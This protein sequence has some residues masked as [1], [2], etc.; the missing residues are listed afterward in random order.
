MNGPQQ[1]VLVLGAGINGVAIA[2]ELVLNGLSVCLVDRWDIAGGTTAY[3]S[4]LIHGGLRYLEYGDFQLVRESLAERERLLRLAPQFVRPLRLF[5][6]IQRRAS[7]VVAAARK[8][9]GWPLPRTGKPVSRGLWLVQTGLQLYDW[10]AGRSSLPRHQTLAVGDA[11][12]PPVDSERFHW[13]TSY[14]DAQIEFPE[15][16]VVAM[17][18]D[19][20]QVASE[21]GNELDVLTYHRATLSGR[22][23]IV[24][25]LAGPEPAAGDS[26][27]GQQ[28][29]SLTPAAIINATGAWVDQTLTGLE[30]PSPR[31]IGG[32]K[33]SHFLTD[34]AGLREALSGCGIYAEARDGRPVFLLPLGAFSMVGT[35]D[36]PYAQEPHAAVASDAELEY[37]MR[38]VGDVFPHIQLTADDIALHYCGVRPLPY[39]SPTSPASVTRRHLLHEHTD[40]EVP[41]ISIIGGKLTTCRSLAEETAQLVLTKLGREVT[42][43]SRDRVIPGGEDYPE[44]DQQLTD[45]LDDVA[46]KCGLTQR[47]VAAV[48]RLC[49]T[50]AASNLAESDA[51]VTGRDGQQNLSG[52]DLPLRFVR[53]VIRREWSHHLTDLV[54]RRLMLLFSPDLTLA[55]LRHLAQVMVEESC[56]APHE[57]DAEIDVC[58]RRLRT[59]FGRR[60]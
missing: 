2:R 9:F 41:T 5:I 45:R 16:F 60:I 50:R 31:L 4:R 21:Q 10:S 1:N 24:E 27:Q 17:L 30:I 43:T 18:S 13:V 46:R 35:T 51:A 11:K 47:Q 33:G 3:S 48:F 53:H 19:A 37:L 44:S 59:H 6:P 36:L 42:S 7:G 26:S 52:T 25:S 39:V 58:A 40:R 49:G 23:V 56:L 14:Y 34:H 54:E 20:R 22:E 38:A 8:F 32:T 57:V 12:S 28:V 55:T 15:R 29:R